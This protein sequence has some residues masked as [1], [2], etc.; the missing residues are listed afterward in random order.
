[1]GVTGVNIDGKGMLQKCYNGV[2]G[3]FDRCYIVVLLLF[4]SGVFHL[5]HHKSHITYE[6]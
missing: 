4:Y 1:M 2:I 5:L 6:T 3:Q